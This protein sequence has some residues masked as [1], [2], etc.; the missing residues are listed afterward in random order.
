MSNLD[1]ITERAKATG[2]LKTDG[3]AISL[4]EFKKT[5]S[6][7]NYGRGLKRIYFGA[8]NEGGMLSLFPNRSA[9]LEAIQECYDM[10]IDIIINKQTLYLDPYYIR[11]RD[12]YGIAYGR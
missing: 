11:I 8:P 6:V 7:H 5:C 2:F 9:K 1:A 12:K 10:L 3:T 4:A